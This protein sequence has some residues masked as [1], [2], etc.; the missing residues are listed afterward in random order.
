MRRKIHFQKS[1]SSLH[2]INS[3]NLSDFSEYK[4][5]NQKNINFKDFKDL[6]YHKAPKLKESKVKFI[7]LVLRK[8]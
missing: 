1:N 6:N 2:S 5:V 7:F 3:E 4:H 8:V